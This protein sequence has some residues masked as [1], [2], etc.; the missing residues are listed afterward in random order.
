M[1]LDLDIL[2][3]LFELPLITCG[4]PILLSPTFSWPLFQFLIAFSIA[5]K[6]VGRYRA[7]L[8]GASVCFLNALVLYGFCALWQWIAVSA[9]SIQY[10]CWLTTFTGV[11]IVVSLLCARIG[12]GTIA[13]LTSTAP[14]YKTFLKVLASIYADSF[15][16][17]LLGTAQ[18]EPLGQT[19]FNLQV[20]G[21]PR[22]RS[23]SILAKQVL[24]GRFTPEIRYVSVSDTTTVSVLRS[25]SIEIVYPQSISFLQL[26]C[27]NEEEQDYDQDWNLWSRGL[28][29]RV[30]S[31]CAAMGDGTVAGSAAILV[32]ASPEG[33]LIM[34]YATN[35]SK[36]LVKQLQMSKSMSR[37]V[38]PFPHGYAPTSV[39][40]ELYVTISKGSALPCASY[41]A[42]HAVDNIGELNDWKDEAPAR[43]LLAYAFQRIRSSGPSEALS[44][45]DNLNAT[46]AQ[47]FP[48]NKSEQFFLKAARQEAATMQQT[49][50]GLAKQQADLFVQSLYEKALLLDHSK[51]SYRLFRLL[52]HLDYSKATGAMLIKDAIKR[53][54]PRAMV[55]VG[56]Q[57]SNS[58]PESAEHCR[59]LLEAAK[60]N[61]YRAILRLYRQVDNGEITVDLLPQDQRALFDNIAA[62]RGAVYK[63]GASTIQFCIDPLASCSKDN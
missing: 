37:I 60:R 14:D 8:I 49:T 56:E 35:G 3:R 50:E 48:D 39:T 47:A 15:L 24:S 26:K 46:Y 33:H 19:G 45:A 17:L 18:G 21:G 36:G 12:A 16:C 6:L 42:F 9:D 40:T 5:V 62:L 11:A 58:P 52:K 54:N 4:T 28:A 2:S 61:N 27:L 57:R 43:R 25:S 38:L 53:S 30:E 13:N 51:A 22:I 31:C 29:E 59:L 23:Q 55:E 34:E 41:A 44:I 1:R 20:S 10:G 32:K 7:A 63:H